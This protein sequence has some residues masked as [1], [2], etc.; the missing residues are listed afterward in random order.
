MEDVYGPST[1]RPLSLLVKA[2]TA[3]LR[4]LFPL[5]REDDL[6]TGRSLF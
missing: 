4:L 3:L 5:V 2:V 1:L 6:D